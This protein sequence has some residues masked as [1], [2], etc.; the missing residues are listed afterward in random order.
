MSLT[1]QNRTA[2]VTGGAQGL[3]EALCQRFAREGAR[4]A[5]ADVNEAGARRTAAQQSSIA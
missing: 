5:V 3:G 2:I 4:V 1:L